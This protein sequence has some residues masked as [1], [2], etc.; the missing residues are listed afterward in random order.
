[1]KLTSTSPVRP[2][3]ARKVVR[4]ATAAISSGTRARNEPNTKAST[5]SA[6][7]APTRVSTSTPVSA[8][9]S[10]AVGPELVEAGDL[11]AGAGREGAA[12]AVGDRLADRRVAAL[13]ALVGAPHQGVDDPA[14]VDHQAAVAGGG[15]P[16]QDPQPRV[17]GDPGERPVEGV[18]GPG[19]VDRGAVGQRRPP[20]P[21]GCRG[22]RCRRPPGWPRW[23]RSPPRPGKANSWDSRPAPPRRRHRRRPG[24]PARPRPRPACGG[25]GT[26]SGAAWV[27][28]GTWWAGRPIVPPGAG[29]VVGQGG[30]S[31]LH[32]P[33]RAGRPATAAGVPQPRWP[34][35]TRPD[36]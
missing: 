3:T 27:A 20:G 9:S 24:R 15:R 21:A 4:M 34:G 26:G 36:S 8:G 18:A 14:A 30:G 7:T 11:D 1:M 2:S 12:E 6:P 25:A 16:G 23:P 33:R 32:I 35:L 5:H 19:A 10:A 22:R 28:S 31:C 13:L 29:P 17:G